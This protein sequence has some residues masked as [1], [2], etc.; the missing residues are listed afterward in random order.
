MKFAKGGF[1]KRKTDLAN[2]TRFPE[3]RIKLS[4]PGTEYII[5]ILITISKWQFL[6]TTPK[7]PVLGPD[8]RGGWRGMAAMA[9]AFSISSSSTRENSACTA[10]ESVSP[11]T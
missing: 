11:S 1:W 4:R 3:F 9:S 5:N 6:Q 10:G 7:L 8:P 2:A